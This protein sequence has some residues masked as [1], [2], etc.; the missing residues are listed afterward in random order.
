MY[1]GR[2]YNKEDNNNLKRYIVYKFESDEVIGFFDDFLISNSN[3]LYLCEGFFDAFSVNQSFNNTTAI[4]LFGKYSN[5]IINS[6]TSYLPSDFKIIILLDSIEKDKNILKSIDKLYN[7]LVKYF[8]NIF[9]CLLP[10][11]DCNDIYVNE[12]KEKLKE[13]IKNNTLNYIKFKLKH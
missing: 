2:L 8:N 7:V 3:E 4:S 1:L 9:I 6:L 10:Y 13:I 12:G 5:R 11:S